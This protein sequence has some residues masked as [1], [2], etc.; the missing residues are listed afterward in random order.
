MI[1]VRYDDAASDD[2][3]RAGLYAGDLFLYGATPA[4][5]AFCAFARELIEEAFAGH[6]PEKAQYAIPVE[7]YAAILG[8]LKPRFIHHVRSKEFVREMLAERGCDLDQT[9]FDV[10][11]MRSSTSNDYLTSGIA[12]AWHPHRDT[13]FSAPVQQVNWWLPIYAM[14]AGNGMAFHTAYF[15]RATPNT[16]ETYNYYEWNSKHRRAATDNVKAENRPMPRPI[17]PIDPTKDVVFVTPVGGVQMFSGAQL[18]S[19]VP[20]MTGKTRFSIDFRT[21]HIGDIAAGRGAANVDAACTGT[22]IRDFLR[23]SDFSPMPEE[24]VRLFDDGTQ[25]LGDELVYQENLRS[26]EDARRLQAE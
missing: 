22:S 3:R 25:A 26:A 1:A 24:I 4:T 13:W 21:V 19:S 18:H 7:Q 8:E 6:D 23:A 11:R 16:S 20:N 10:P 5:R 12:Y 9:Y 17:D 2:Q 15:G 14:E